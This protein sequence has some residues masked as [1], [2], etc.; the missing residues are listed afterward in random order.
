[1]S[2]GNYES[3][4]YESDRM[5]HGYQNHSL[6]TAPHMDRTSSGSSNQSYGS[7]TWTGST[8]SDT[9]PYATM[10]M[11]N[12]SFAQPDQHASYGYVNPDLAVA[13]AGSHLQ[14]YPYNSTPRT[15]LDIPTDY[16]N[17]LPEQ[18]QFCSVL[19]DFEVS[20]ERAAK[21]ALSDINGDPSLSYDGGLKK[22]ELITW[23][24]I[25]SRSEKL[26][27]SQS[28]SNDEWKIF[29]QAVQDEL[30]AYIKQCFK[31][32]D[33][34]SEELE[35][36]VHQALR[37]AAI[38]LEVQ[39]LSLNPKGMPDKPAA[40]MLYQTV[41]SMYSELDAPIIKEEEPSMQ[42]ERRQ[43]KKQH[44]RH[45]QELSLQDIP[46]QDHGRDRSSQYV[47]TILLKIAAWEM[48]TV[49]AVLTITARPPRF[50]CAT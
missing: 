43:H 22:L 20:C 21:N 17:T 13:G 40:A 38:Q 25:L 36:A 27:K 31:R 42:P 28:F 2:F 24:K 48:L 10:N 14:S 37:Q 15:V 29:Q 9:L 32:Q 12:Q 8:A 19:G 26:R 16:P 5:G 30:S 23:K 35:W 34:N 11:R 46:M 47:Q 44:G 33:F 45:Q 4:S 6:R 18:Y 39:L 41:S 7:A 1:M 3:N 50:S 49:S